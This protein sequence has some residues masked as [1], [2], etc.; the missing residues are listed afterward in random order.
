MRTG[1]KALATAVAFIGGASAMGAEEKPASPPSAEA[2]AG[3]NRFTVDLYRAVAGRPGNVFASPLNVA[4]ALGMTAAGAKGETAAQIAK[5]LHLPDGSTDGLGALAEAVRGAIAATD[6]G[7]AAVSTANAGWFDESEPILPEFLDRLRRSFGA[8]P[9][10]VDFRNS[11]DAA[12]AVVNRW[13][14]DQ[15]RD[16]IQD[17]LKPEHVRADT[18]FV[19]TSAIYFKGYW[20][21]PFDPKLTK[22]EPFQAAG[23]P[24]PAKMM[25][26]SAQQLPYREDDEA[27]VVGLP[28][29]DGSLAML[30]VLPKQADGL[31]AV[32][33]GL[34]AEKVHEWATTLRPSAVNLALPRFRSTAQLDL[35]DVLSGL[36]MPDAFDPSK[37]D[38]SGITGRRDIALSAVVHKAFVEVEEKGTEAAAATAV[39]GVRMSAI[40]RPPVVSRA[41]RPFL[42]LIRD[43][44]SGAI[45]FIG[46]LEK[47]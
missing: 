21:S 42:S 32:E 47:P 34:T 37:A 9:H 38:F 39:V 5:V 26:Q 46:R 6:G 16:K 43:A 33:A 22:D 10:R 12:R 35:K 28:Y 44:K 1:M 8:E 23:G 11:P 19:L 15:T 13:V 45:L 29:K 30:V 3:T 24:V 2:V 20:A 25:N 17:L 4:T 7:D 40:P 41:D 27:Q 31:A 36:G 18:S 14:A